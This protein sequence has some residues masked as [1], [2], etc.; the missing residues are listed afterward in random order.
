MQTIN[1]QL[2]LLVLIMKEGKNNV[3]NK[4]TDYIK[5]VLISD[6]TKALICYTKYYF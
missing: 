4:E 2:S 6:K 1:L 3:E 5:S